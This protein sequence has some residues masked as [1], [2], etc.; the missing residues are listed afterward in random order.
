[1]ASNPPK[2]PPGI[3]EN[4]AYVSLSHTIQNQ[5]TD[6]PDFLP[7]V[8]LISQTECL[9]HQVTLLEFPNNT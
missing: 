4:L 6:K 9:V 8:L 3:S 7:K 2:L 5:E 1:M